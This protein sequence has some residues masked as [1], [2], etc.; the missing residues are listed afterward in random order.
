MQTKLALALIAALAASSA[1]AAAK[2]QRV[3]KSAAEV[4]KDSP[5]ADWRALDP[6]NTLLMNL[7]QGQVVIELAPRFAPKLTA[8]IRALARASYFDGLAVIR[9]QENYVTQWGD[10]DEDDA[11]ARPVPDGIKGAKEFSIPLKGLPL[12]KLHETDG[13]APLNGFVDGFPVAA[14]PKAGRAWLAHCYSTVGVARGNEPDSGNGSGL[15]VAIGQSPRAL[16]NNIA[17]VGRVIKGMELL[18]SLPRGTG[19]LGFYE[20]PEQRT[21]ITSIKLA[22]DLPEAERPKLQ[23][24]RTDSKTWGELLEAR[25]HRSG[26]YIKSPERTDLCSGTVPT[27]P[28]P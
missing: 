7:P 26:W 11:K 10:P 25:R 2:E 22:A 28:T 9:V 27:R 4:L 1:F 23:V 6:E 21:A 3:T 16:E 18:G 19:N 17:A 13:W 15:Y 24:L 8:N 20:K 12:N 5:N 14:D